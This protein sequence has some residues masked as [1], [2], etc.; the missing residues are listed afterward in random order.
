MTEKE[1]RFICVY[2][3]CRKETTVIVE[4]A[5]PLASRSKGIAKVYPCEH[6]NRDNKIL[7]PDN[8]DKHEFILG[9][10]RGFL[11]YTDDDIPLLQG[12]KDQ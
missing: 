6:C 2:P 11:R 3:D 12:E 8:L 9:R 1:L 10:D 5:K 4:V 7:V